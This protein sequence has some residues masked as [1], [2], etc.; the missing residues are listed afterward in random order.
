MRTRPPSHLNRSKTAAHPQPGTA[1][2][3]TSVKKPNDDPADSRTL[4]LLDGNGKKVGCG[5]GGHPNTARVIRRAAEEAG[6]SE[7]EFYGVSTALAA[8]RQQSPK[9][10]NEACVA[11]EDAIN[12]ARALNALLESEILNGAECDYVEEIK[13]GIVELS[14]ETFRRLD[15]AAEAMAV[16]ARSCK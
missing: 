3:N 16:D 5:V 11:L 7:A 10:A 9:A 13:L 4:V 15:R 1:T 12:Q 2:E 14:A 8:Y 6:L